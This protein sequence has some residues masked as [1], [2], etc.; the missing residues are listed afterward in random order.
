SALTRYVGAEE[1]GSTSRDARRVVDNPRGISVNYGR[2]SVGVE[3][4]AWPMSRTR[5]QLRRLI[6]RSKIMKFMLMMSAPRGSGDWNVM[7]W[8]PEDLKAHIR[9][10]RQF[11]ADLK[12]GGSLVG[13]EGLAAPGQARIVRAGKNGAP[14]LT[15]GP[16]AEAKEF[17]AG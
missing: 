3:K 14:E 10:M 11:A 16:F 5:G 13:A 6:E 1:A 9:F 7:K 15:D 12:N 17:L 2:D 8:A 4:S